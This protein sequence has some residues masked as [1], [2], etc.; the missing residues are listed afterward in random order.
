MPFGVIT[1]DEMG[2]ADATP[3]LQRDAPD[4]RHEEVREEGVAVDL[5]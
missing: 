3:R 4:V 1:L 5:L 2:V